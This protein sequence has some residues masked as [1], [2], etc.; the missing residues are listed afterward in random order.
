MV[1][2]GFISL[3]ITR[4]IIREEKQFDLA[5]KC[6]TI[7][8]YVIPS[9]LMLPHLMLSHITWS[10]FMLPHLTWPTLPRRTSVNKHTHDK[11]F[12]LTEVLLLSP[13]LTWRFFRPLYIWI[14]IF[15]RT[16]ITLTAPRTQLAAK[17]DGLVDNTLWTLTCSS[18]AGR[19]GGRGWTGWGGSL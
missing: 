11:Y 14:K 2:C 5:G 15:V 1:S 10:T 9:H 3:K 19:T 4:L 7:S 17:N 18:G 12:T 6:T 16:Y 13:S 8:L